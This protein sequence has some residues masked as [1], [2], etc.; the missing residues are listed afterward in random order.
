M[1]A[2]THTK[3]SLYQRTASALDV[4]ALPG[5]GY[6]L[7]PSLLALTFLLARFWEGFGLVAIVLFL[8][9]PGFALVR[10]LEL[11]LDSMETAFISILA[12][13]AILL[14]ITNVI[15]MSPIELSGE[16][17]LVG[18]VSVLLLLLVL[19]S[20]RRSTI[21]RPTPLTEW[22]LG[23]SIAFAPLL[24]LRAVF[25]HDFFMGYDP[26][27]AAY[28][29]ESIA[30]D[31]ISP[32]SFPTHGVNYIAH[33]ASGFYY[34]TAGLSLVTDVSVADITKY[35]GL[36]LLGLGG[37]LLFLTV[38]AAFQRPSPVSWQPPCSCLTL[39][40]WTAL[41]CT[42]G[43]TLESCCSSAYCSCLSERPA[44]CQ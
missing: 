21:Q 10:A 12:G 25:Q 27:T 29:S 20:Q 2:S 15:A 14:T 23:L 40:C 31:S 44:P 30:T 42:F 1:P 32:L 22:A 17:I 28:F 41:S 24:L 43:R 18:E 5:Y 13:G 39:S 33:E 3:A 16:A 36:A 11:Q 38:R 37:G 26:F 4:S 35:G 34:F 8:F 6:V 19:G 7:W 9:V